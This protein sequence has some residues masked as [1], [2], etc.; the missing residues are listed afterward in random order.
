MTSEGMK[1]V[2]KKDLM[3]EWFESLLN[4]HDTK[5]N[6]AVLSR[7]KLL[8]LIEEVKNVKTAQKEVLHYYRH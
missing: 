3:K 1:S 8:N 2:N 7:E 4:K 5:E 6:N